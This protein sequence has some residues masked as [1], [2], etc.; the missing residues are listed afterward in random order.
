MEHVDSDVTG[1]VGSWGIATTRG[2]H[3]SLLNMEAANVLLG[4]TLGPWHPKPYKEEH[5]RG[6]G[7]RPEVT[8][9]ASSLGS[10]DQTDMNPRGGLPHPSAPKTKPYKEEHQKG[11]GDRPEVTAGASSLGSSDQT[12]DMNPRGGYHT[13]AHPRTSKEEHQRGSGDQGVTARARSSWGLQTSN[14][15]PR[16]GGYHTP[17][18]PKTYKEEHQRGSGDQGVT[19]GARSSWGLQTSN[20]NPRGGNHTPAHPEQPTYGLQDYKGKRRRKERDLTSCSHMAL[21]TTK[22]RYPDDTVWQL[23][24]S[25]F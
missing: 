21:V 1:W 24:T 23:C 3:S 11:S 13:P 18:R 4:A 25:T 15:N 9:G 5:Q 22:W 2:F 14:M 12:S 19:A 10:S 17:A 6:S 8:A 7:D 16:G 20:M